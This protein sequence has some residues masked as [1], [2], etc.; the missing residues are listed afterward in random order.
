MP[1]RVGLVA[2]RLSVGGLETVI[3]TLAE[4]LPRHGVSTTLACLAAGGPLA[5]R[6]SRGCTPVALASPLIGSWPSAL[7]RLPRCVRWLESWARSAAVTSLQTHLFTSL[8]AGGWVAR[9]RG[10]PLIHVEQNYYLWKGV[11]ARWLERWSLGSSG[12]IVTPTRVLEDH[13]RRRL[14]LPAGRV[15]TI[16]NGV[17]RPAASAPHTRQSWGFAPESVVVLVAERLV[18]GKRTRW[19]LDAVALA[20]C[21][22]APLAVVVAG[23]GACGDAL[24]RR[25]LQPDL[26]GH[27]HFAGEVLDLDPFRGAVDIAASASTMEG[28]GLSVVESLA[29]GL[30]IVAIR[31][32]VTQELLGQ[33]PGVDLVA[34]SDPEA[35]ASALVGLARSAE[36]RRTRGTAGALWATDRFSLEAMVEAYAHLHRTS[37]S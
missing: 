13:H 33:A 5:D 14:G 23:D 21:Q 36:A 27:V 19:L 4:G 29:A 30:P 37:V 16:L 26:A 31:D 7:A 12:R 18:A 25:A 15:T 11:V 20:R 24:R 28:F 9:R 8:V 2:N 34:P 10:L 17:P 6:L 3:T 22:G 32:S 35:F 1:P